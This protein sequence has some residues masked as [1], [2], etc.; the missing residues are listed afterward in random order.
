MT[1]L[2]YFKFRRRDKF[3]GPIFGG[4]IYKGGGVIFGILIGL[5]ILGVYS[6]EAYIRGTY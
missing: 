4:R 6:G 2:V 3:D 1:F 5:H